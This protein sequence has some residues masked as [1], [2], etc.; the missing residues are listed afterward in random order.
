M[1]VLTQL[2]VGGIFVILVLQQIFSFLKSKNGKLPIVQLSSQIENSLKCVSNQMNEYNSIK[3]DI[4][5][6]V[7]QTGDLWAMHMVKDKDGTPIWYMKSSLENVIDKLSL[8][9]NN[10][11][12]VLERMAERLLQSDKDHEKIEI[13]IDKLL[14]NTQVKS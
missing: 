7:K 2:G 14:R 5:L 1:E 12:L 9:I 11:T 10:Q 4:K 8:S 13:K 3:E 6:S